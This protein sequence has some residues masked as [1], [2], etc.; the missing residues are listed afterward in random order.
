MVINTISSQKFNLSVSDAMKNSQVGPVL[1][2]E[3]GRPTHV[4]LTY[5]NYQRLSGVKGSVVELLALPGAEDIDLSIPTMKVFP[6][7]ADFF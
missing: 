3:N 2:T 1:I 5:E 7:S 6:I 4:L